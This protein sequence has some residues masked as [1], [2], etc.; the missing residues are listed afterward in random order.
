MAGGFGTRLRP[1]TCNLPKP[2]VPMMNKPMIQ[3]I[4]ELLRSHNIHDV[5]ATVFFQPE[6][7]TKDFDDGSAFQMR[8]Q[9][10]RSD[11]D[12]GTAG[13]VRNAAELLSDRFL[14][15]SGDILTDIDLTKAIRFHED[16]KS[17]A[18]IVL[19][20]SKNPLQYGIVITRDDGSI[21]RF[22]EKP[23]W[24]EVFSDTI[25]TG[26][27]ILEPEVLQ[28][29][30][31]REEFDFSKDLFPLMIERGMDI[32]GYIADGYWRDIGNLNEYQEG[33][34]D[35]L[36]GRVK[37]DWRGQHKGPVFVGSGTVLKSAKKNLRGT[38]LIGKNCILE[39][40]VKIYSSV[41]GDDCVIGRGAVIRNSIIWNDVTVGMLAELS[42][43][44][45]ATRCSIGD[46]AILG[47]NVF[48]GDTCIIGREARLAPNV[49]LWPGKVVEDGA[50]LTRSLVWE[51]KWLSELF[52]DSRVTGLSNVEMNP[53]FGAR[54]GAAF[55][56][57]VGE[58][59]TVAT[60]RDPD[61]VSRMMSR[62]IMC[63]LMSAG[64][65]V[66]DLRATPIPIL[67][68]ELSSGR[69]AGG[70]HVRKSPYDRTLTDL[71][72]FDSDGKDLPAGKRKS[73]ERLFFGEDFLRAE[74]SNVGSISFPERTA[75][76]YRQRFVSHIDSEAINRAKFRV[77]IDYSNGMT[78]TIF[79]T[80][81]GRLKC[82]VVALNAYLD[83][84]ELT[85]D[86]A[87]FD[88]AVAQL[89]HIVTSLKYD[90]GFMLDAGGEKIFVVDENG[91]FIDPDRLLTIVTNLYLDTYP[92]VKRI[93]VP[94]N[95]TTEVDMVAAAKGV[96]VVRTKNS[97]LAMMEAAE[98]GI[99]FVGGTR[100]G[101]IF[102]DFLFATDGMFCVAKIL[103]V[104]AHTEQ[105]LGVVERTLPRLHAIRKDIQCSWDAKGR[106]MRQLMI[107]SD[108]KNRLLLDGIKIFHDS[109]DRHTSVFLIPDKERPMFHI[110]AEAQEARR[111][112][113]LAT[114]Y[115]QKVVEWRDGSKAS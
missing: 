16:R 38:I 12:Y 63:G 100:G 84:K 36:E 106:V 90:V 40:D 74:H 80:I 2:M 72:F 76:S 103:E 69:A 78:S 24:G 92:A 60:C 1:L 42:S 61:N 22:L 47:D 34:I 25:N 32:F 37:I 109:P 75:E 48:I 28:L 101:F 35:C 54:L 85:R 113:E 88:E 6:T 13:G 49:K 29:I 19:S 68:H 56:S 73:L 3:Y 81:L 105:R 107:D 18:T 110:N 26:I 77:V 14:I 102:S 15:I 5:V 7:I 57:F 46:R 82:Q 50:I 43:S 66:A 9:Y 86:K 62:A 94:I 112:K 55:G 64:V 52:T 67:R 99:G 51:D 65:N 20:H 97:H 115:E 98:S 39:E 44:V 8:I 70:I 108:G 17:R 27:Y 71:V 10:V 45:V 89:A 58:G 79:P 33:H 114:E 96:Q 59:K 30:P 87:G 23:S 31:H 83:P 104:M 91:K 93:A 95:A 111:A 11:A 21:S 4:L 53:E 41:I